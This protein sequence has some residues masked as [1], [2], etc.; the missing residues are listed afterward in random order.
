MKRLI[1]I[2]AILLAGPVKAAEAS[3]ATGR[4]VIIADT[5]QRVLPAGPNARLS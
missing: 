4:T 5:I 1:L 3:D 2:I